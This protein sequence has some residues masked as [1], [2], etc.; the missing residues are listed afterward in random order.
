LI[1]LFVLW[2]EEA[3]SVQQKVLHVNVESVALF[4]E[5]TKHVRLVEGD[6]VVDGLVVRLQTSDLE[7][8][9]LI[10]R[11]VLDEGSVFD[12]DI[13]QVV[14]VLLDEGQVDWVREYNSTGRISLDWVK[15]VLDVGVVVVGERVDLVTSD[16][17]SAVVRVQDNVRI[18]FLDNDA[19]VVSVSLVPDGVGLEGKRASVIVV[20]Q[21][22]RIQLIGHSSD[23]DLRVIVAFLIRES[24]QLVVELVVSGKGPRGFNLSDEIR[25]VVVHN[26]HVK[27]KLEQLVEVGAAAD[28]SPL[29]ANCI[30]TV[31]VDE[32]SSRLSVPLETAEQVTDSRSVL[33]QPGLAVVHKIKH[34]S[35]ARV[36]TN[37]V[38]L[39]ALTLVVSETI[40]QVDRLGS[41][42][43]TSHGVEKV[44]RTR[45]ARA[46]SNVLAQTLEL[47]GITASVSS[48]VVTMV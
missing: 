15:R 31:R 37:I 11:I 42:H 29:S 32:H 35:R 28:D 46:I 34:L 9:N 18:G 36:L 17:H 5:Q 20:T 48:V 8:L 1:V 26:V 27:V 39:L 45:V 4:D 10:S 24:W 16:V 23:V 41:A 13:E 12:V 40:S 2:L 14:P 43:A 22:W 6:S 33:V 44:E 25:I 7:V 3:I 47:I 21:E 38:S 19:E 30:F